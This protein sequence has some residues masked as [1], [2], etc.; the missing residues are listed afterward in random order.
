M[1]TKKATKGLRRTKK[2]T[3]RVIKRVSRRDP[4]KVAALKRI[5]ARQPWHRRLVL[6]PISV[7]V[8]LC[9]G[10]LIV[11]WTYQTVADYYSLTATV[12]ATPLTQGAV[13]TSPVNNA[14]VRTSPITVSGTCPYPSYVKLYRNSTFS[15]VAWC[16]S[17]DT[18]SISSSLFVGQNDLRAQDYNITDQPGPATPSVTV[19]YAPPSV[20]VVPGPNNTIKTTSPQASPPQ[21]PLFIASDFHYQTFTQG[22]TF[23]WSLQVDGG[24][25]PYTLFIDWGDGQS[26]SLYFTTDP[27]FNI[28]HTY[29]K[30]GYYVVTVTVTDSTGAK[31]VLQL[32]A[33]IKSKSGSNV[34]APVTTSKCASPGSG[35]SCETTSGGSSFWPLFSFLPKSLLILWP[36]FVAV[37]LMLISFWLGERQEYAVLRRKRA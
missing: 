36:A 23:S 26:S 31:S 24:K 30:P 20:S 4:K 2:V 29:S 1:K 15:G 9:A 18:F 8:I 11:G 21:P 33:L 10:V 32:A 6:H 19:N 27:T 5:R 13:I 17:N 28:S 35:A 14:I 37:L 34:F 12:A 16:L 7:M 3:K 25:A 22:S